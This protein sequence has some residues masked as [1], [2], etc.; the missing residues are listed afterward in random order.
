MVSQHFLYAFASGI[1]AC[2][3]FIFKAAPTYQ[4]P[5]GSFLSKDCLQKQH[6]LIAVFYPV[7]PLNMARVSFEGIHF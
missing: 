1:L 3:S 6:R 2:F 5:W 7:A 4:A